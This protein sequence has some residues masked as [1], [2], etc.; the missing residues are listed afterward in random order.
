MKDFAAPPSNTADLTQGASVGSVSIAGQSIPGRNADE[1]AVRE[2]L[3][4]YNEKFKN[5]SATLY[6]DEIIERTLAVLIG[7]VK[8]NALLVGPAGVGKTHIVE[9]IARR[10]AIKD[11]LIPDRLAEHTIYELPLSSLIAG[12]GIVGELEARVRAVVDFACDPRNRAIIFIDEIHQ[13]TGHSETYTK[14]AQILKPAMA[15]GDI[16]M[17]GATTT[18][19]ARSLDDDPA[20]RRRFTRL[21]VDELSREQ[22]FTILQHIRTGLITHYQGQVEVS[23]D[24][25]T[26]LVRIADESSHAGAHRPDSAIT[27]LDRAMADRVLQHKRLITRAMENGDHDLAT[28]LQGIARV[29]LTVHGVQDVAQRILTGSAKAEELDLEALHNA[30]RTALQGQDAAIEEIT[31]RITRE[32]LHLFPR[33][34][35]VAW[36]FA[37]ASGV[38]KTQAAKILA[39][40]I[41]GQEPIT[42]NMTEYRNPSAIT[43]LIGAPPGYIGSTSNMELPFDSLE[44]NPHRVI[45]LDEFEKADDAVKRLFLQV[46]DEGVMTTS[47]GRSIDFSKAIIIATTNA[48]RESLDGRSIGF[49]TGHATSISRRSLASALAQHFDPELLGRFSLLIGFAPIT[50]EIYHDVL[51]SIYTAERARLIANGARGAQHLPEALPEGEIQRMIRETFVPSHGARPAA[52]TV[53]T[54]IEDALLDLHCATA[55]AE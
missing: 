41:T 6:R 55:S 53:R 27:L 15:R 45:L 11:A 46:L 28:V 2:M 19:E 39:E 13:L 26:Q 23:D 20:F 47:R 35:P 4:D 37:G 48:A 14:V 49:T 51:T 7:S 1:D 32:A 17:I 54:W 43:R 44:S 16:Q 3:I 34:A 50:Q 22:T 18:Q 10:I 30:L 36:L 8:P 33:T 52:R 21:V 25:L 24:V 38:G 5:A 42:L 40:Q 29:Q 9:D 12:A 31:A